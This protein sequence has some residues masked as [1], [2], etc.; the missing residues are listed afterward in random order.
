MG[1]GVPSALTLVKVGEE[2]DYGDG[3]LTTIIPVNP[4]SATAPYEQILDQGL[5]GIAARDFAA[6]QG[7]GRVEAT[8]E[9]PCYPEAMNFWA[10]GILGAAGFVLGSTPPS[11]AVAINDGGTAYVY[12]GLMVSELTIRYNAAEGLVTYSTNLIGQKMATT[13]AFATSHDVSDPP[14]GWM[15]Y[16][17]M[18]VS[19]A[20][21]IEG[22][23]TL[24]REIALLYC[25]SSNVAAEAQYPKN[26]YAGPLEVTA[27]ATLDFTA[28]ALV[29]RYLNKTQEAFQ[30]AFT[31][32]AH[33][34]TITAPK[35]DFGEGPVEIDR[36]GTYVTLAYSMRALYDLDTMTGPVTITVT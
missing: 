3:T 34:L 17:T 29:T 15:A 18:G 31:Y 16:A 26:A 32:D 8:L 19:P 22:E 1:E 35:M 14:R 21:V 36:S 28:A 25:A 11:F 20:C 27:R 24:S 30:V 9:G 23:W 12:K 5:R 33:G 4:P 7:A 13:G 10:K 6:Y 2:A